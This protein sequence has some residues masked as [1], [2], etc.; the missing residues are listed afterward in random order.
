M[1]FLVRD[2]AAI[3]ILVFGPAIAIAYFAFKGRPKTFDR[4]MYWTC[5]CAFMISG[6]V[7]FGIGEKLVEP[8][9][10]NAYM[11]PICVFSALFLFGLAL[12]CGLAIFTFRGPVWRGSSE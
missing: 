3:V 10:N 5:F 2:L 8:R 4:W 1:F 11:Q 12:G 6:G 9:Y 7:L